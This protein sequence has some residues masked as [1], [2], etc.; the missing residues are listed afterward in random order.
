MTY[1]TS[2]I[3]EMRKKINKSFLSFFS[4]FFRCFSVVLLEVSRNQWRFLLLF[5]MQLC[6]I[7]SIEWY[8]SRFFKYFCWFI[9][10]YLF[11][12]SDFFRKIDFFP[13]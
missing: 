5:S 11:F 2:N 9:I 8:S 6:T 4:F 12:K 13:L 10:R 1:E 3:V 7:Y